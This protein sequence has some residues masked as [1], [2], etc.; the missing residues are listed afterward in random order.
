MNSSI[1]VENVT[2]IYHLYESPVDR[3]KETLRLT[4]KMKH[5]DFYALNQVS[6][7]IFPGE[8]VGIIGKNGAGKST[9]L[10]IITGVLTPTEG[11]VHINGKVSALLELGAGFNPEY[12]GLENVYLNGTIMGFTR[13]EMDQKMD[14]ILEFAD[15]GSFIHQPVKSYSSGMFM[16]LA[17]SV[18]INVDPEILII[19]EALSVGDVLFQAKCFKKI[20]EFKEMGKTI[21]FVSHSLNNILQYC[22]RCF[23]MSN[24][25]MLAEGEAAAMV[26]LYKQVLA[27]PNDRP[28]KINALVERLKQKS[29]RLDKNLIMKNQLILNKNFLEYGDLSI[30]IIDFG[31]VDVYGQVTNII[32]AAKSFQIIIRAQINEERLN[33]IFAFSI[34]DIHGVEITGT[35]TL[36][37]DIETGHPKAGEIVEVAFSQTLPLPGDGYLLSLGCTGYQGDEFLVYH[38]LY[39]IAPIQFVNE[40]RL[41]GYF[42]PGS[43]IT[44]KDISSDFEL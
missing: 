23:V 17:F 11:A 25:F 36:Y 24:G 27:T 42:D 18:A 26:D 40:N 2:K 16:R 7:E 14:K 1:K 31:I 8:T 44:M 9:L 29:F 21:L 37:K 19:D 38:R 34:K 39:D 32:D 4:R 12:T 30:K 35:N 15:I 43:S 13:E 5:K 33:P 28:D 3:L 6:F 10:K 22:D 41:V 20:Q